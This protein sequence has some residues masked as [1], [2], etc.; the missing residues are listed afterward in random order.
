MELQVCVSVG[1]VPRC[2]MEDQDSHVH[3]RVL[4]F[5]GSGLGVLLK[6]Q[7]AWGLH[8]VVILALLEG[9]LFTAC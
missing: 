5:S 3:G 4:G 1:G 9:S 2:G 6:S 8:S 7:P